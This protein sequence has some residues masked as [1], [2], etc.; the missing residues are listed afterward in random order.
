MISTLLWKN[1]YLNTSKPLQGYVQ[2]A[3]LYGDAVTNRMQGENTEFI[4]QKSQ[5]CDKL[6]A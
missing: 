6:N 5:M 2:D 1:Y 3:G 4:S